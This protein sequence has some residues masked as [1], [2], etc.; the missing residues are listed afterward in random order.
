MFCWFFEGQVPVT[1]DIVSFFPLHL[2]QRMEADS[3]PG[4]PLKVAYLLF[5]FITAIH[6]DDDK[7]FLVHTKTLHLVYVWKRTTPAP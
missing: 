5:N 3:T 1:C 7:E 4:T 6:S 2:R